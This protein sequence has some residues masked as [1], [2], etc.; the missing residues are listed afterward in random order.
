MAFH[1]GACRGE[2]PAEE[3]GDARAITAGVGAI[4]SAEGELREALLEARSNGRSWGRIAL[5]LGVSKQAARERFG[6]T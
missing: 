2:H 6:I 3:T 4:A 1:G 5:A